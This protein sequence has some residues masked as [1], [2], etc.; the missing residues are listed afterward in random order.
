MKPQ[1]A[2]FLLLGL[3]AIDPLGARANETAESLSTQSLLA[4]QEGRIAPDR[5]ARL[6]YFKRA[7]ALASRALQVREQHADAHFALFCS[8]G[9]QLRL[10]GENLSSL[11]GLRR[12]LAELDRTLE[13]NPNHVDALS[14]KGTLLMK[15]PSLL[16]G[17]EERGEEMLW[18]V[19]KKDAAAINARLVLART[20]CERGHHSE[21]LQLARAALHIANT[22]QRQDLIPEARATVRELGASSAR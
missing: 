12:V 18:Q 20:Y 3:I 6:A 8:L 19:I 9:E 7:E 5:E 14:A 15:L 17:D 16:G 11:F 10:D 1:A 22:T 13:L 4:C 21:A 2:I